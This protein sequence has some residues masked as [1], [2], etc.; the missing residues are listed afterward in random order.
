MMPGTRLVNTNTIYIEAPAE[1]VEMVTG[2]K[3]GNTLLHLK[4]AWA[5]VSL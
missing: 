3:G 4:S 2:E 5:H 1:R